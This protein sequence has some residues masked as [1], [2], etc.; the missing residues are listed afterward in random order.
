MI[1]RFIKQLQ[2]PYACSLKAYAFTV[3]LLIIS[4]TAAAVDANQQAVALTL[5]QA[6][7]K[8]LTNNPQ[9][10]EFYYREQVLVGESKTA[11]LTSGYSVDAEVENFLGTGDLSGTQEAEF[12]LSLSSVIELGDKIHARSQY[13]GAKQQQLSVEKQLLSL[14]VLAEVTR[15]YVEVLAQQEAL[16]VFNEAKQLA[17]DALQAVTVRVKAGASPLFEQKRAQ[18]ALAEATLNVNTAKQQL[19]TQIN[20]LAI[21]WGE[22]QPSFKKVE[23]DLFL[24]KESPKFS[25][26]TDRLNNSPYLQLF[27]EESRLQAAEL[28]IAQAA[29]KPNISWSAGIRHING[30]DE[31]ALVAGVSIPLLSQSRNAGAYESQ[32]ARTEQVEQQKQASLR[33]LYHQLNQTLDARNRALLEVSSF[34]QGIIPPLKEAL[35]LVEKA[36]SNGRFSYL[37]WVTTR[38]ELV[39]AQYALIAAAKQAHQRAADIEALTGISITS[40]PSSAQ[41]PNTDIAAPIFSENR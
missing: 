36:Y 35:S 26:L 30:M 11:R 17:Q 3:L 25:E 10:H 18:A 32:R 2:R 23:G 29:N 27:A 40:V 12:S 7:K 31:T 41:N 16:A 33:S 24:L 6:I 38:Q 20:S 1:S 15:R 39:E 8:T 21:M 19:H 14:D 5:N 37:E 34:Q 13:V 22:Q 9:L 28:R 4:N